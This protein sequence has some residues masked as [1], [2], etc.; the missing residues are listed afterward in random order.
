MGPTQRHPVDPSKHPIQMEFQLLSFNLVQSIEIKI[1]SHPM[2]VAKKI[3][4]IP[5]M[6]MEFQELE[7]NPHLCGPV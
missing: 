1:I 6:M 5:Y 7:A 3:L 2:L 4:Y